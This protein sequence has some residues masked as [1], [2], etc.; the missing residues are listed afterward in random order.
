[1]CENGNYNKGDE[2]MAN[3]VEDVKVDIEQSISR[4]LDEVQQIREGKLPKRS[5]K[6]MIARVREKLSEEQ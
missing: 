6:D 5:Y 4:S 3:V 2:D 1:M